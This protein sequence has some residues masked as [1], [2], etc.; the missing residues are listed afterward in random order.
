MLVAF[1]Y[2]LEQPWAKRCR[3][4]RLTKW[5]EKTRISEGGKGGHN[6]SG[7]EVG[8]RGRASQAENEVCKESTAGSDCGGWRGVKFGTSKPRDCVFWWW[9]RKERAPPNYRA[10]R[11][12]ASKK[13]LQCRKPSSG[14]LVRPFF[15]IFALQLFSSRS[16]KQWY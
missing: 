4:G 14:P 7:C 10:A 1:S 2:L 15:P 5:E 6:R 13:N 12:P 16:W 3:R 11:L 8:N 9:T